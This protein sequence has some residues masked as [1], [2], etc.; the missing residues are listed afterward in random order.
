MKRLSIAIIL[1]LVL[2]AFAYAG[3]HAFQT[4]GS[5][6]VIT[7]G[8]TWDAV[9]VGFQFRHLAIENLE[10]GDDLFISF[11]GTTAHLVVESDSSITFSYLQDVMGTGSAPSSLWL[12]GK[13]AHDYKL[14]A[15]Y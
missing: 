9:T 2:M 1:I 5:T 14:N 11:D 4:N 7:G 12:K 3:I 13:A 15:W 6:N 8:I 10:A